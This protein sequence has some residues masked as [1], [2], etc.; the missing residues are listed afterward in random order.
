MQ[1][2]NEIFVTKK[3]LIVDKQFQFY[4]DYRLKNG[5]SV[6]DEKSIQ[7]SYAQYVIILEGR[8]RRRLK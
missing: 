8:S 4:L 5:L 1:N 6:M 3:E 7:E 2:C